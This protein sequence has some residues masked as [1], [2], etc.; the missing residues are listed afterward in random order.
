MKHVSVMLKEVLNYL[1]PRA[2]KNYID[3]TCGDGG[4][5][6]A[7]L[8][9]IG[10]KGKVLAIDQ[11]KESL[12]RAKQNLKNYK[13]QIVFEHNN[14]KNLA[15]IVKKH[16]FSDING[17]L[18]DLGLASWQI[19]ESGLG[20]SFSKNEA[21]DMRLQDQTLPI[22]QVQ[23]KKIKD[24]KY[25]NHLIAREI[26]NK[27]SVKQ[28]A[29]ILYQYG[30]VRGSWSVARRID[31]ARKKEK[32]ETTFDLVRAVGTKK[33]KVLAPIFQALRIYVNSEYENLTISLEKAI[34][35]LSRN[36]RIVVISFYSGE[37]RIVKNEFRKI[38]KDKKTLEI[39]TKKPITPRKQEIKSN[40]RSR[41][42]KL[43]AIKKQ[44]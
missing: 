41:S 26:I 27:F 22:Q 20:I 23:G 38:A 36:G 16:N 9:R 24:Q 44:K 12:R 21:L 17:I 29:N 2:G 7:I 5:T 18:Y 4:H 37:D 11:S 15:E 14:F 13:N 28:I 19:E 31:I 34:N 1:N 35:I 32:I 33:P 39:L 30:D 6:K 40:P 25:F 10:K 42:A 8:E 43:R 3:A